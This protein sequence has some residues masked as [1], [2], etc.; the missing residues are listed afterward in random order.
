MIDC[1]PNRIV[2]GIAL[3]NIN[4][5]IQ[6]KILEK[7]LL[8]NGQVSNEGAQWKMA[9]PFSVNQTG[10]FLGEDYHT[11]TWNNRSVDLGSVIDL[12]RV[13][14]GVRFRVTNSHLCLEIRVTDFEY[15]TGL[16]KNP[17]HSPWIGNTHQ[18]RN[19]LEPLRPDNPI[20]T[21]KKSRPIVGE[22]FYID[23]QPSDVEKDAA[24]STIPFI[25]ATPLESI[26]PLNGIGLQ[27]K[28]QIGY[29]GFIA[30]TLIVFDSG[31][32]ITPITSF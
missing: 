2:A 13:V 11:I 1:A 25:D 7:K 30:P 31:L 6:F 4:Q 21:E 23:F 22:N 15:S 24:Q 3:V 28:T 5:I 32:Y 20:K 16:L 26:T 19:K 14:T 9:L 27:Y 29:G 18:T 10:V 12:N 8:P 17:R